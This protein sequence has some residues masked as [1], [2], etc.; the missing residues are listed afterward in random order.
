M[1]LSLYHKTLCAAVQPEVSINKYGDGIPDPACEG[2]GNPSHYLLIGSVIF[3]VV[4][5]VWMFALHARKRYEYDNASLFQESTLWVTVASVALGLLWPLVVV[6]LPGASV[7]VSAHYLG[8]HISERR[9]QR[10]AP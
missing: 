3:L 2:W 8:K 5:F 6:I 10:L 1:E 7:L 4:L 9:A